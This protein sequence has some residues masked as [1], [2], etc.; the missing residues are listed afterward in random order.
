VWGEGVDYAERNSEND[1]FDQLFDFALEKTSKQEE[2]AVA[3][4]GFTVTVSW[5]IYSHTR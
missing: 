1:E 2:N 5:S 3:H 4:Q